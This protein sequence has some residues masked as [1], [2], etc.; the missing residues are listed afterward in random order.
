MK[1][2][3]ALAAVALV[4][5]AP[6]S[7]ATGRRQQI[8]QRT[9]VRGNLVAQP[10]VAAVVQP[11]QFQHVQPLQVQ[12]VF[13]QPVVQHQVQAVVAQPQFVVQQ[14]PQFV[15]QQHY[16]QPQFLMQQQFIQQPQAVILR[17]SGCSCNR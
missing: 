16:Q 14:Q 4:A 17:Q 1:T 7:E 8:V 2:L 15:V 10:H 9:T 13:A 12:Q 5:M 11:V 3:I 6:V